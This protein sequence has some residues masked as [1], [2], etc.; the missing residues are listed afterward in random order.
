MR[1][2]PKTLSEMGIGPWRYAELRAICRQYPE[3]KKRLEE[4]RRG[5]MD[6]KPGRGAWR[7]P[8][9]TGN[10][11]IILAAMPE[12]RIV[13]LVEGSAAA[14]A[15]PSIAPGLIESVSRGRPYDQLKHKPPMGHN[16]FNRLRLTFYVELD[17]RLCD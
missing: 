5:I 1:S 6:R 3:A 17:R 4:A 13:K 10:S 9:P 11:A 16:Q 8:D 14:V 12:A 2:H 7:Q 15:T